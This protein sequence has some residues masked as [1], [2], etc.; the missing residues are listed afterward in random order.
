MG[1]RLRMVSLRKFGILVALGPAALTG[2]AQSPLGPTVQTMVGPH[3]TFE[4]YQLDVESCKQYSSQQVSG[5][6][7]AANQQAAAG[8]VLATALG[9][10]LGAAV[11]GGRGAAEG[12]ALGATLGAGGAAGASGS[13]QEGIQQQ[14]DNAFGQCMYSKG[15]DVAGYEPI[16]PGVRYGGRAQGP[17]PALVRSVQSQLIRLNYLS[18]GADGQ[19]GG[20]TSGAI[21]SFER[22]S[23]LPSD[24]TVSQRLLARLQATPGSAGVAQAPPPAAGWVAPSQGPA[25]A[26]AA[27]SWVTPVAAPQ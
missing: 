27:S 23:G 4:A 18:G 3:K 13:A 25:P 9:A 7:D 14:Y 22:A 11:G 2:C 16:N 1:E 26:A 24:G 21:R 15:N 12:A 17:N 8:A 6:A 10:G 19:M 20:R 5:Q